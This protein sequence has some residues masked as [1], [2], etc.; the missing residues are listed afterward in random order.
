MENLFRSIRKQDVNVWGGLGVAILLDTAIQLFWKSAVSKV[1][2]SMGA[3][4]TV[5]FTLTQ[6][7]FQLSLLFILLQFVNWM[8]VL[9]RADLSYSQ[10]I[11]ALSVVS[12]TVFS[13]LMLH[14]QVSLLRIIGMLFILSGVWFI[15][16][17]GHSTAVDISG[18]ELS[19]CQVR[20][21]SE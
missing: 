20:K 8:T 19:D 7:L 10:P 11:T 3:L 15:S 18:R 1:P 4:E 6:P 14:E 2:S 12:V 5:L 13:H 21:L 17:T 9:A 16:T